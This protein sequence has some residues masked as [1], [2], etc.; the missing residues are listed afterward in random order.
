MDDAWGIYMKALSLKQPWAN[1]V[2]KG[3][4]TIEI[5]TW[6]TKFRGKFLIHASKNIDKKY[7]GGQVGY[8][9]LG[10]II[11]IATL[12]DVV[13]YEDYNEFNKDRNR[14]RNWIV[15]KDDMPL[16]GFILD[17]IKAIKP[18]PYKGML[19]FFETGLTTW[20]IRTLSSIEYLKC[21]YCGYLNELECNWR[22]IGDNDDTHYIICK[23]CKK[24]IAINNLD[25]NS[26]Y[27][28][29]GK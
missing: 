8:E 26:E 2:A 5:R 19:N 3:L 11:A 17:D 13:K 1:L 15:N 6:N 27:L 7:V 14:H 9:P 18:I 25:F 28:V 16:Y 4:K 20:D 23:N 24:N 10:S 21:R 29:K 12:K 22:S